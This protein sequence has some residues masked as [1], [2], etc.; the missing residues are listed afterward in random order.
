MKRE[1]FENSLLGSWIGII[2]PIQR[3]F[4]QPIKFLSVSKIK[5][6]CPN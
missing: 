2:G 3:D 5:S 6:L 4:D 1:L